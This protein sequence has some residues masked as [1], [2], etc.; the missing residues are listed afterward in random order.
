M[1][2]GIG[3]QKLGGYLRCHV[4]DKFEFVGVEVHLDEKY[5]R[6]DYFV[7]YCYKKLV[8]QDK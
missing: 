2:K 4:V 7:H 5:F 6:F 8:I 1:I 3:G